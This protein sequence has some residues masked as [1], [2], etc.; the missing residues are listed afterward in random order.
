MNLWR[1]HK[2]KVDKGEWIKCCQLLPCPPSL[3]ARPAGSR[4][5]FRHQEVRETW[6]YRTTE[7]LS[8]GPMLLWKR[9]ENPK[10][11]RVT[12]SSNV[13][14][15]SSLNVWITARYCTGP[16]SHPARRAIII[17]LTVTLFLFLQVPGKWME[18]VNVGLFSVATSI[19]WTQSTWEASNK[20]GNW[21]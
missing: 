18:Q 10:H 21:L 2:L 16:G 8:Q 4:T 7:K 1:S 14:P 15:L 20:G 19:W 9:W 12:S 3:W 17:P 11:H 13:L 5:P 6:K